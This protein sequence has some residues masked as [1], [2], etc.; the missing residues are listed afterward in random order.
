MS[1]GTSAISTRFDQIY[2]TGVSKTISM[3][4]ERRMGGKASPK[5]LYPFE[6]PSKFG[7]SGMVPLRTRPFLSSRS[8][9][10]QMTSWS[11]SL[12]DCNDDHS[13]EVKFTLTGDVLFGIFGVLGIGD[14]AIGA[15]AEASKWGEIKDCSI[16]N[17]RYVKECENPT[18]AILTLFIVA[19]CDVLADPL[20]EF[21][22]IHPNLIFT[23]QFH[24][25]LSLQ[26][27]LHVF[28]FFTEFFLEL[29]IFWVHELGFIFQITLFKNGEPQIQILNTSRFI[30]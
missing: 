8:F 16:P 22:N 21:R 30:F 29:R 26:W 15:G 11:E 5:P 14:S 23:L 19:H 25:H 7:S 3:S 18:E 9:G 10:T 17:K 20:C 4:L 28:L 12:Q 24:F 27:W 13:R 6:F 2:L 1:V